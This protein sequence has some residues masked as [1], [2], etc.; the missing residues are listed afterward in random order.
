MPVPYDGRSSGV[1]AR[2]V[3]HEEFSDLHCEQSDEDDEHASDM[4][5]TPARHPSAAVSRVVVV[6]GAFFWN[7]TFRDRIY[8]TQTT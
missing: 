6:R 8:F 5:P 4:Y 1:R 7:F 2:F 3:I